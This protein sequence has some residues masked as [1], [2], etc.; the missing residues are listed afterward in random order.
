MACL[1]TRLRRRIDGERNWEER[2]GYEIIT[3]LHKLDSQGSQCWLDV[4]TTR[5]SVHVTIQ[6]T[7]ASPDF[8]VSVHIS[9]MRYQLNDLVSGTTG[10]RGARWDTEVRN[11]HT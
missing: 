3:K 9:R 10:G 1:K 4:Y 6:P 8:P 7:E 5:V 2:L 11:E